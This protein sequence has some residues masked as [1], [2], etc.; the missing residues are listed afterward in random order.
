MDGRRKVTIS[1]SPKT[2]EELKRQAEETG[3]PLSQ[4]IELRLRGWRL[5]K[6]EDDRVVEG[7]DKMIK[8]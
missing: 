5:V 4:L 1:L 6:E 3:L 7:Y 2:L 8:D